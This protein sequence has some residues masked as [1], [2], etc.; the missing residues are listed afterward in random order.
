LDRGY[1][2]ENILP[3]HDNFEKLCIKFN[4]LDIILPAGKVRA[5]GEMKKFVNMER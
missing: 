2:A 5:F 1:G 4:K 3:G